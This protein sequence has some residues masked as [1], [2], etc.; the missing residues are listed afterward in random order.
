MTSVAANIQPQYLGST[1]TGAVFNNV[2]FIVKEKYGYDP[3]PKELAPI[4]RLTKASNNGEELIEGISTTSISLNNENSVSKEY[5]VFY[6]YH[7]DPSHYSI[8]RTL[9]YNAA[10]A[11]YAIVEVNPGE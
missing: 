10:W 11:Q 2:R 4:T 6:F 1:G 8:D 3:A 7:N 5:D 9:A